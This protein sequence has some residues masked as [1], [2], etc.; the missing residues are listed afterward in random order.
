MPDKL[1]QTLDST[2]STHVVQHIFHLC[3]DNNIMTEYISQS[4]EQYIGVS[5]SVIFEKQNLLTASKTKRYSVF[6]SVN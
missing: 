5:L 6:E 2:A 1:L 3:E 4:I